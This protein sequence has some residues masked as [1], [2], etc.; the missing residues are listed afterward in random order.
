MRGSNTL[1]LNEQTVKEALQEYFDKRL[2]EPILKIDGIN[3]KQ[4]GTGT[5][6]FEVRVSEQEKKEE[7]L[8][9]PVQHALP[10]S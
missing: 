5:G 1:T 2:K 10:S 6:Q 9:D 7:L 3:Q 4:T 8:R